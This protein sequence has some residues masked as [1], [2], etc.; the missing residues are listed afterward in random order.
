MRGAVSIVKSHVRENL[1]RKGKDEMR[2][3]NYKPLH[4]GQVLREFAKCF[5]DKKNLAYY[6]YAMIE[7][8]TII[9]TDSY[10]V[11]KYQHHMP[12]I[13]GTAYVKLEH[14][15]QF[16]TKDD[17]IFDGEHLQGTASGLIIPAQFEEVKLFESVKGWF[18]SEQLRFINNPEPVSCFWV[19]AEL[20]S[21]V[22]DAFDRLGFNDAELHFNSSSRAM[23]VVALRSYYQDH[24]N[25]T[26]VLEALIMYRRR[27]N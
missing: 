8:D 23:F 3:P 22:I 15:G 16:S 25:V 9:A 17:L 4:A 10:I 5:K 26:A 1:G 7:H 21:N 27:N 6:P 19:S 14:A 24:S 20:L 11:L 18:S 12:I 2:K 13:D